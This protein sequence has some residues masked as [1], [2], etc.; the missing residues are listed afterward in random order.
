MRELEIA[1]KAYSYLDFI[2]VS[3]VPKRQN[4]NAA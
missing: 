3:D 4:L 1:A 2:K